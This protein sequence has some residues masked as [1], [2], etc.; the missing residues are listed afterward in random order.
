PSRSP[1]SRASADAVLEFP[2]TYDYGLPKPFFNYSVLMV[3]TGV[4]KGSL[5]RHRP[6][7]PPNLSPVRCGHVLFRGTAPLVDPAGRC[8][9]GR[10]LPR[11]LPVDPGVGRARQAARRRPRAP[12]LRH[13]PDAP[14]RADGAEDRVGLSPPKRGREQGEVVLR[15]RRKPYAT[16]RRVPS[17]VR[18][19]P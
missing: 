13:V 8:G 6:L 9:A 4:T 3:R 12:R 16:S 19:Q 11:L 14:A 7:T 2:S 10:N 15:L 17:V 5:G 1:L 18:S